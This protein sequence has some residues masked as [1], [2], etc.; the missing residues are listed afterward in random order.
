[1]VVYFP[2]YLPMNAQSI[3]YTAK[4]AKKYL[5][6]CRVKVDAAKYTQFGR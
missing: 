4:S 1:M 3:H 5:E 2:R 6:L